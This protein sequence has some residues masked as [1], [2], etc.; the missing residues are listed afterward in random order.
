MIQGADPAV[1]ETSGPAWGPRVLRDAPPLTPSC[2]EYSWKSGPAVSTMRIREGSGPGAA[3]RQ[4]PTNTGSGSSKI[5]HASCTA[6]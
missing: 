4:N 3:R 6:C 1:A 5:P 2:M